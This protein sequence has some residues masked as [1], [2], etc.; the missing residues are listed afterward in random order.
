MKTL[1]H[2]SSLAAVLLAGGGVLLTGQEQSASTA[3]AADRVTTAEDKSEPIKYIEREDPRS[4]LV[5]YRSPV[6]QSW[7]VHDPSAPVYLSGP[8]GVQVFKAETAQFGWSNDPFVR[9]SIQMGGMS[10]GRPMSL[11]QRLDAQV[12]PNAES[13]GYRF[14]G[15]QPEPGVEGLWQRLFAAMPNNGNRRSVE[16]LVT[17]WATPDG[18]RA[19]IL[20]VKTET[21]SAQSLIWQIQ[22]TELSAPADDYDAAKSAYLYASAA[23]ELNPAW[24][25]ASNRALIRSARETQQYWDNAAQ[26][27]RSAH[28]QRMQAIED[29][30]AIARSTANTYSDILDMSHRGYLNRDSINDKGHARSVDLVLGKTQIG[31]R[32]TGESYRVD[33]DNNFYWVNQAGLYLGTDNAL[34]DPRTDQATRDESWTRFHRQ[35]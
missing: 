7:E 5:Q 34:F 2:T 8:N 25:A 17:D 6:P 18:M 22:T 10:V 32:E 19:M 28:R 20:L 26:I 27:S 23:T 9:Q 13:Q 16:A 11:Q 4:G 33:G 21:H 1:L 35:R 30:G 24:I 29:R 15:M 3:Y 31:N 12:R 14:L